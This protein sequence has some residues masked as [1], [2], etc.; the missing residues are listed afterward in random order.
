MS[1]FE[2]KAEE[3]F[4]LIE[5]LLSDH[6]RR[7][8][9][10]ENKGLSVTKKVS[11]ALSEAM[12]FRSTYNLPDEPENN[13]E[14]VSKATDPVRTQAIVTKKY[15]DIDDNINNL[16]KNKNNYMIFVHK[17]ED[18]DGDILTYQI[19]NVKLRIEDENKVVKEDIY[20]SN[21]SFLSK[22][23]ID[24]DDPRFTHSS[25]NVYVIL[26]IQRKNDK[27]SYD[28]IIYDG[29]KITGSWL[30]A[31]LL[32]EEKA[33]GY[34]SKRTNRMKSKRNKKNTRKS[35]KRKH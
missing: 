17:Q 12:K 20:I 19:P 22:K 26:E 15:C 24:P 1:E 11:N 6:E 3:K 27:N 29:I 35:L 18:D 9:Y 13:S 33:G 30:D 2:K 32:D 10:L 34:K 4:R 8:F 23:K 5:E 31:G 16:L 28:D 21:F 14:V 7:L 25:N